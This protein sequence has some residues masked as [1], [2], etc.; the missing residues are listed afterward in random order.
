MS[1]VTWVPFRFRD[2]DAIC[3]LS[4]VDGLTVREIMRETGYSESAIKVIRKHFMDNR[5]N[6]PHP[7][8]TP[9]KEP[10]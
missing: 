1:N 6:P 7:P 2:Q 8:G 3:F 9:G 10:A 4:F 5:L